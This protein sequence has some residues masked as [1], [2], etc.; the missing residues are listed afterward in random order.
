MTDTT[1]FNKGV[2]ILLERIKSNPEEFTN[3]DTLSPAKTRTRWGHITRSVFN[4]THQPEAKEVELPYL[5]DE[6]VAVIYE[7]LKPLLAQQFTESIMEELL[8]D[9]SSSQKEM[10]SGATYR[11]AP[12]VYS[13][14]NATIPGTNVNLGQQLMDKLS[15]LSGKV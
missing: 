1:Q 12:L 8:R 7:A 5:S 14:A 4:R 9:D 10:F 2:Q 13:A 3:L 6:E 11:P 15:N